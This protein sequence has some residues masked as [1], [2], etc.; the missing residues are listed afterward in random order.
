MLK[1]ILYREMQIEALL[2]GR[3]KL[4]KD[5]K[6]LRSKIAHTIS[7]ILQSLGDKTE[8]QALIRQV[9]AKQRPQSSR[10]S[11]LLE[12][13]DDVMWASLRFPFSS[14]ENRRPYRIKYAID[15]SSLRPKAV[16]D[17]LVSSLDSPFEKQNRFPVSFSYRVL[18]CSFIYALYCSNGSQ[19]L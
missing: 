3:E 2:A 8:F 1:L 12:T 15:I 19:D 18:N 4:R 14:S 13:M 10:I 9:E 5:Q 16:K 17:A 6:T 7:R 11:K